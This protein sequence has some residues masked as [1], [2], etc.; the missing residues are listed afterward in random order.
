MSNPLN[1]P[2][3]R[4]MMILSPS[5]VNYGIS[6]FGPISETEIIKISDAL[7]LLSSSFPCFGVIM[8]EEDSK[9]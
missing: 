8:T 5:S 7:H 9:A 3:L 6:L 2:P 4:R 1:I